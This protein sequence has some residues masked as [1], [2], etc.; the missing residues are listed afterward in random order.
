MALPDTLL[1]A[2]HCEAPELATPPSP[3]SSMFL[4]SLRRGQE[5]NT[6]LAKLWLSPHPSAD[7]SLLCPDRYFS[8]ATYLIF[9]NS[10]Y[11]PFYQFLHCYHMLPY[12]SHTYIYFHTY[13]YSF[14]LD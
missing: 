6:T 3:F 14:P 1:C 8:L 9:K 12:L 13:I 2:T 4:V 5:K 10:F 11:V 7:A